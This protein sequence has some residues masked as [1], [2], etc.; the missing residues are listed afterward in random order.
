MLLLE[1]FISM[2]QKIKRYKLITLPC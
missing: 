1:S 2:I